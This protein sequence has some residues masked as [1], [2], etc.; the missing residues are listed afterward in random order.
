MPASEHA[1]ASE[2]RKRNAIEPGDTTKTTPWIRRTGWDQYLKGSDRSDLL[3]VTAEPEEGDRKGGSEEEESE[4]EWYRQVHQGVWKAMSELAA[5]S[6]STVKQSGVM[7]RLEAVRGEVDQKRFTPLQLYQDAAS[8]EHRGP[9]WQQILISFIRTQR[10]HD[11]RS[12]V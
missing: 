11:W 2:Q 5:I 9:P 4:E 8:I 12:P 10:P 3:G 1:E 7:L 6:Q